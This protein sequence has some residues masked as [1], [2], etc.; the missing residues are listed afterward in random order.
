MFE[1]SNIRFDLEITTDGG[2][3]IDW[4]LKSL[5]LNLFFFFVSIK[6]SSDLSQKFIDHN[7]SIEHA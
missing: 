1:K 3:A 7:R 5:F 2:Y 6:D 4:R